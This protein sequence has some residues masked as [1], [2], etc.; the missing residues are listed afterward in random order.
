MEVTMI[1][2]AEIKFLQSVEVCI[3][4]DKVRNE[5]AGKEL[6]IFSTEEKIK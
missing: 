3:I 1:Y 4:T 6:D 2:A 5:E